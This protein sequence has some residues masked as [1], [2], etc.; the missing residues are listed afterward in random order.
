MGRM[1]LGPSCSP[2]LAQQY[3]AHLHFV[4]MGLAS[5]DGMQQD[6]CRPESA[7]KASSKQAG[8]MYARTLLD[9]SR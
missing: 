6:H 5:A 4:L 1:N 9:I 3:W 2:P 8:F 7:Y